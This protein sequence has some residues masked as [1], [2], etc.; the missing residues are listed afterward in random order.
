MDEDWNW[1]HCWGICGN[2]NST[3]TPVPPPWF[4]IS[5]ST[6]RKLRSKSFGCFSI[7]FYVFSV[8]NY[9][10]RFRGEV[11]DLWHRRFR[12]HSLF[13]RF[14]KIL[15]SYHLNAPCIVMGV[16]KNCSLEA[17]ALPN[18][19]PYSTARPRGKCPRI[20]NRYDFSVGVRESSISDV[21]F[22]GFPTSARKNYVKW[23]VFT[24][25]YDKVSNFG[26]KVKNFL[27]QIFGKIRVRIILRIRHEVRSVQ[28]FEFV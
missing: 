10:W 16:R 21:A 14:P 11:D 7:Y 17:R 9:D 1:I 19:P 23:H 26:S 12:N 25:S 13:F 24:C 6:F 5:V 27:I 3:P 18:A 20:L 4:L 28:N 8:L 2:S 15:I 22:V